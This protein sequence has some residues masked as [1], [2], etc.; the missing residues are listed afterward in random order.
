MNNLLC[1]QCICAACVVSGQKAAPHMRR[2]G[3][4]AHTRSSQSP[5]ADILIRLAP[6]IR[7]H[8]RRKEVAL[9]GDTM[10][11]VLGITVLI[12]LCLGYS[13]CQRYMYK[14]YLCGVIVNLYSLSNC[15]M[16]K[17]YNYM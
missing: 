1:I 7:E 4:D 9:V 11:A 3:S 13:L 10:T 14:L 15:S 17:W 2:R 6:Y 5:V 8:Q 16:V 12:T